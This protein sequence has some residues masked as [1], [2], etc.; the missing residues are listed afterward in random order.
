MSEY[1]DREKFSGGRPPQRPPQKRSND[2]DWMKW[3]VVIVLFSTGLWPIALVLM[4]SSFSTQ[5]KNTKKQ[6]AREREERVARALT[7]AEERVARAR[8]NVERANGSA[9][10]RTA[11]QETMD[12]N[13][14]PIQRFPA[15]NRLPERLSPSTDKHLANPKKRPSRI[16]P[17]SCSESSASVCWFLVRS[18][19]S[20]AY[21]LCFRDGTMH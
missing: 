19:A 4:L 13:A 7:Q 6:A 11:V 12:K 15:R 14:P 20:M 18:F 21:L 17:A 5:K 10:R 8:E 1:Y 3:V 16:F 9:E 2:S